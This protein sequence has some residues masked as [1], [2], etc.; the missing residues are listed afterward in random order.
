[1]RGVVLIVDNHEDVSDLVADVLRDEGFAV[2]SLALAELS[3]VQHEVAR[4]EP[5]AV[6]LDG[7]DSG[8]N[9][10]SWGIAAWLHARQ[11]AVPVVMFTAHAVDLAEGQRAG[12]SA[13]P[14]GCIRGLRG[15]AA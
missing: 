7:A 2:S 5:D 10:R 3:A 1:M 11:P 14:A 8:G 4:L 15:E 9:G 12:N 6:L 13:K